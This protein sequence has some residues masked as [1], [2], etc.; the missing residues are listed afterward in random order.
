MADQRVTVISRIVDATTLTQGLAVDSS[1]RITVATIATSVTPGTSAA[2]LGKAE[3]AAHSSG[4]TGVMGLAVRQDTPGNLSGTDGD[5]E[6]LQMSAGRLWASSVITS[7]VPGTAAT[8]LGKAEDAAHAS[9]DTGGAFWGVRNDSNA[10]TFSGTDGDYT[11]VA[12]DP[13]GNLQVDVLSGG[14]SNSPTNPAFDITNLTTPVNLAAGGT[15][16]ADSADIP[17]K[18]LWAV[19]ISSSVAWKGILGTNDNGTIVNKIAFFGEPGANVNL[20]VPQGFIQAPAAGTGT[21]GF[22]VALA[23]LDTS[24]TADFYVSYLFADNAG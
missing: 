23:N 24:E 2:H 19:N 14:G 12:V 3:D 5:Y 13:Q 16:N 18:Y 11:P 9:G 1:G 15:G 20:R 17:S 6:P 7:L 8:S 10:T 21:Q 22:R 4:D